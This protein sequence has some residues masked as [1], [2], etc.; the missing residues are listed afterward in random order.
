MTKT[1]TRLVNIFLNTEDIR[2]SLNEETK[3]FEDVD[4]N[5]REN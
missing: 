2:T 4:I 5:W 3:I 1:W